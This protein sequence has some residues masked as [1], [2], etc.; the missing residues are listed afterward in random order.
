MWVTMMSLESISTLYP[1]KGKIQL[2]PLPFQGQ[3][4]IRLQNVCN[5]DLVPV[6]AACQVGLPLPLRLAGV[7]VP[8]HLGA[9]SAPG[10]CQCPNVLGSAATGS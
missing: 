8:A 1:K 4:R 10:N 2:R 5:S 6:H 9:L 7:P 3:Y